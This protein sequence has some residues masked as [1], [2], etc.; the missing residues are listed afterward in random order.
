MDCMYPEK[1]LQP[2]F[3]VVVQDL[4]QQWNVNQNQIESKQKIWKTLDEME[5]QM[6]MDEGEPPGF[7]KKGKTLMTA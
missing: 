7:K 4:P 1:W 3:Q 6:D 5:M 2:Y